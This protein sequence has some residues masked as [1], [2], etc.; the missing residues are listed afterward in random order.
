M[1]IYQ[2]EINCGL[3]DKIKNNQSIAFVCSLDK[4]V[5]LVEKS[6]GFDRNFDL[7]GFK[8]ILASVGRN[9]NDDYFLPEEMWAARD[10]PK[11]KPVNGWHNEKDI[12]GV[13]VDSFAIDSAGN[14]L[15]EYSPS[16]KDIVTNAVLWAS[17]EDES[18]RDRFADIVFKMKSGELFVSM[19][20]LFREFDYALVRGEEVK[21][22]KRNEETAFL[23]RYLRI[24]GGSGVYNNYNICRVLRNFT[25]SAKAIVDNPANV[26]SIISDDLPEKV[27]AE[28]MDC[29]EDD[30]TMYPTYV[31]DLAECKDKKHAKMEKIMDPETE[32]LVADLKS[33]L[34]QAKAELESYKK[35]DEIDG[36][37]KQIA[38]LTELAKSAK[39]ELVA[40]S[41][42]ANAELK[43]TVERYEADLATVHAKLA[44]LELAKTTAQ[45][46]ALLTSVN[47]DSAKAEDVLKTWAS[48]S[49]EQFKNIVDLY[50]GV[51]TVPSKKSDDFE[52][53]SSKSSINPNFE[54]ETEKAVAREKALAQKIAEKFNFKTTKKGK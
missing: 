8:S 5:D 25:F 44:E 37:Q 15:T 34:E 43:A 31:E 7:F 42:A 17:W 47:I 13:I 32:K 29:E 26:R 51:N 12:L 28:D 53:E 52:F 40:K 39:D 41:E 49:D 46:L 18:L 23:T 11:N 45:R 48:V 20:C 50:A 14:I 16:I 24:F 10:T 2:D 38:E 6:V 36:L 33:Q 22:V 4:N 9:K 21:I 19:E 30:D 27:M 54:T 1:K 3:S 35:S